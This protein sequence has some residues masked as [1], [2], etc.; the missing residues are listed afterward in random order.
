MSTTEVLHSSF[1]GTSADLSFDIPSSALSM[2]TDDD[3]TLVPATARDDG[4]PIDVRANEK[5]Y[6]EATSIS[7]HPL[8]ELQKQWIE[9]LKYSVELETMS[10]LYAKSILDATYVGRRVDRPSRL[11]S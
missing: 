10:I 11:V 9:E 5:N 8:T 1:D 3:G 4:S 2:S 7:T 6:K